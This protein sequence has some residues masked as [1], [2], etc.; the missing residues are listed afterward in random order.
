MS[1]TTTQLVR[2]FANSTNYY[3]APSELILRTGRASSA[4]LDTALNQVVQE[5]E[6]GAI[7]VLSLTD[8][9]VVYIE[10]AINR[11]PYSDRTVNGNTIR[12]ASSLTT[13]I[14]STL[15]YRESVVNIWAAGEPKVGAGVACRYWSSTF[16]L[17]ALRMLPDEYYGNGSQTIRFRRDVL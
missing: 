5:S 2:L 14:R 4:Q 15:N 1:W 12:G 16:S 3:F 17:D 8:N 10:F 13:L 11:M 7:K 9:E 6:S